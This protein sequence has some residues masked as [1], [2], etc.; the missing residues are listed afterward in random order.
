MSEYW[1]VKDVA[2]YLNVSVGS[3]Y[4]NPH[5]IKHEFVGGIRIS[6]QN[7]R[8]YEKA[9]QLTLTKPK[10]VIA[11]VSTGSSMAVKSGLLSCFQRLGV[12]PNLTRSGQKSLQYSIQ[13]LLVLLKN[14]G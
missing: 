6:E 13:R 5:L 12:Q 11:S 14:N 10:A 9:Y 7:L 2:Q 4:K 3:V 8:E 1:K